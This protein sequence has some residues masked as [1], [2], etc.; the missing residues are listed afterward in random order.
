MKRKILLFHLLFFIASGFAQQKLKKADRLFDRMAYMEAAAAYEEYLQDEKQPGITTITKIADT[1]YNIG[2]DKKALQWLK[3]LNEVQGNAMDDE[4]F[5]RYIQALRMAEDYTNADVLLRQRLSKQGNRALMERFMRQKKHLDSISTAPP[6]Y[7]VSN[8]AANTARADFGTVFYGS[9]IVYSSA[10]DSTKTEYAWNGQP[11]LELF[12]AD[13]NAADGSFFN[14]EKFLPR[15]QN[16]YHNATL[17]FSPD[18]K[19]VYYSTNTV[20]WYGGLRND[21]DG[22]NN[23]SIIKGEIEGNKLVNAQPLPFNSVNY[24]VGHPALTADGKWLYFVSDMPGGFGETDIYRA[25]VLENGQP[26][27]PENLGPQVNTP[28]REMFPFLNGEILYFSSDGHYGLGGLDVFESTIIEDSEFSEPKNIGR[29]VNS[30]RDDFAYI[31][32]EENTYGYFSSNRSGGKGDD[33]IYYF[34][35][36]EQECTHTVSGKVLHKKYNIPVNEATVTATDGFGIAVATATTKEDGIYTFEVPCD[37]DITIEASKT[38]H[39]PDSKEVTTG[40]TTAEIKDVNLQ[41]DHFESYVRKEDGVEK[42]DVN[43]IFFDLDKYDIT[44]RAIEELDKVVYVMKN[45][46][47]IIIRIESHT[48]SR[49]SEEYNNTLSENRAKATYNYIVAQGIDPARIESAKGYGETQLRNK[50][51]NDAECT[52]EEHQ[53]NRRSDFIIVKK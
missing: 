3:K 11:Y 15:E 32:D 21:K 37:A 46:P 24:S 5:N 7:T 52:E 43:P 31:T 38:E 42:I 45:F 6:A 41:L 19:T 33:D 29:P 49:A 28:G 22:T 30:N 36:K 48:D 18:M 17:T 12:V 53:L 2:N 50:C 20:K 23:L 10:K 44:P 8:I 51:G 47:S 26:G 9:R 14:E 27:E 25:P 13:R 39:T 34:T 1:Y 4:H 40:K 35:K 16:D